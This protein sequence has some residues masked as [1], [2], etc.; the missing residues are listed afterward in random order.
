MKHRLFNMV[1]VIVGFI[2]SPLS[3]WNDMV[4]NVPISYLLSWPFAAID[5]R[6]FLPAFV[7]AYWLTNLIG[8][9]MIHW[10]GH[11][12]IR[13]QHVEISVRHSLLASLVYTLII[14]LLVWQG[15]LASPTRLME[16]LG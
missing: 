9:L 2:L 10:G 8:L 5:E 7:A 6:L 3:W 11:K 14:A 4:V 15:W 13:G 12:M 16:Y 1:L